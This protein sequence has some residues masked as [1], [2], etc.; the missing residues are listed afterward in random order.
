ML[1]VVLDDVVV[2]FDQMRTEA[3]VETLMDF[4]G[5]GRQVLLFTCHRHLAQLFETAGATPIRLP[6]PSLP[7]ER[8]NVG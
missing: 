5:G 4:A 8:R 3:A 1:P 6:E 7:V 2:N